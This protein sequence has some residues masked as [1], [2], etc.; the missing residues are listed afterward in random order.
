M[1]VPPGQRKPGSDCIR[2]VLV[3]ASVVAGLVNVFQRVD[4]GQAV[5]GTGFAFSERPY[6]D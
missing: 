5:Y 2:P 3:S 6:M 4:G 1:V